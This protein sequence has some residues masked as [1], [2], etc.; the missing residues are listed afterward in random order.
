MWFCH[1]PEA[2][3][4][5]WGWHSKIN[6]SHKYDTFKTRHGHFCPPLWSKLKYLNN[7]LMDC[8]EEIHDPWRMNLT[9]ST[10]LMIPWLFS[11]CQVPIKVCTYS[12]TYF[13]NCLDWHNIFYWHSWSPDYESKSLWSSSSAPPTDWDL[14]FWI[15]HFDTFWIE[16]HEI[17][18]R[19]SCSPDDEP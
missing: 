8:T 17:R 10:T 9:L 5:G 1:H 12:V 4:W 15:K 18:W 11:L 19:H 2:S 16:H 14:S 3:V 6:S 7:Y 13:N